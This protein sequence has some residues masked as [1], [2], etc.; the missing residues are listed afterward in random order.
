M[1]K[2]WKDKKVWIL[3]GLSLFLCWLFVGQYGIFGSRVD[4]L[5]QHSVIPDYFR[6]RF[7]E[8]GSLFPD[9][10][11]NLGGGQNI[12]N[13]SYYGLFNP[14]ILFSYLLPFLP[15][16]LY[17]MGS[18]ALCYG[19]SVALFYEWMRE[20][21]EF[22]GQV[23]L[24]ISCMFALAAPL[25]YHSYN[26]LMFVNYM[27]FLLLALWGTDLYFTE[28]K[29][30]LLLLGVVGM[31]LSSFYFSIGGFVVLG[32]YG[33]STYLLT[34]MQEFWNRGVR[35][36]GNLLLGTALCGI[37]L[38]PTAIS[39]FSGRTEGGQ[40]VGELSFFDFVPMR[41]LYT[42][43]GLG[44]TT[45]AVVAL[46]A[47]IFRKNSWRE[48]VLPGSLLVVF[49][50]SMFCC[51]LNGGLYMKNKVFIPFLPLVCLQ[52]AR[53][54]QGLPGE[55][56]YRW[57]GRFAKFFNGAMELLPGLLVAGLIFWK[58]DSGSF[59]KI[60]LGVL[61]DVFLVM[62]LGIWY[63]RKG[64]IPWQI[65]VSCV[66]LFF[67]DW[68]VNRYSQYI[69][70]EKEYAGYTDFARG[71]AV[72]EILRE[73]GDWYRM[74]QVG[75]GS[76]NQANLNRI[77]DE[78]QNITSI[79]SSSFHPEYRQFR[80]E[81]F[82]LNEPFRNNMMQSQTDN[83]CFLTFM[84]VRYVLAPWAPDGYEKVKDLGEYQ[85]YKKESVAPMIYA[86][87]QVMDES[88]YRELEFPMNQTVL[89]SRA[90]V[91]EAK[92]TQT[93]PEGMKDCG[94]ELPEIGT[95]L[96]KGQ[97]EKLVIQKTEDGYEITA[98]EEVEV[99]AQLT[100]A[101]KEDTLFAATFQ[102]ENLQPKKDMYI[103]LQ[104]QTNRLTDIRD[105]YANQNTEFSYMVTRDEE[106]QVTVKLGPGHYRIHDI[107]AFTGNV[108][109][110]QN[111]ELYRSAFQAEGG[112]PDGDTVRGSIQVKEDGYLITSIPY[113][114]HF[115]LRIDGQETELVKVNTAFLGAKINAGE[116]QIEILYHAPGKKAGMAL[117]ICGGVLLAAGTIRKK[118]RETGGWG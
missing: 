46:A 99:K 118:R 26:Q 43:Y 111:P 4:W 56:S 17:I 37:L 53:Y 6:K 24:G 21:R 28:K 35:Y 31:I 13:Y 59:E 96:P 49:C 104:E 110:L 15:M 77:L 114:E 80:N 51:L 113:D 117:S 100:G 106:N 97:E 52:T 86:T 112:G 36:V 18:S 61:A 58:R 69:L 107:R 81:I 75:D 70:G 101:D 109:N 95:K 93:L 25:I 34:S 38:I 10:A 82:Q 102:V 22:S 84:G 57:R 89:L 91:P 50:V 74:D 1:K 79:Y 88:V 39:I 7:Y 71:Q 27:P 11:W 32:I 94:F 47:G 78:R 42:P 12:Y 115:T 68:S 63:K 3:L 41:F 48:K 92:E 98:T 29:R 90:A 54:V 67:S 30:G 23:L 9:M 60:W 20:K 8:T 19:V 105:E 65:W 5:S 2:L 116:H 85:I 83:P 55:L 72:Q 16:D 108:K 66:I 44:L 87:D 103:R 64:G 33:F 73:D 45:L 14:V 40:A 62:L 76:M